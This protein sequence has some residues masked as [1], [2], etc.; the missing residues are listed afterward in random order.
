MNVFQLIVYTITAG[1]FFVNI[2]KRMQ[3]RELRL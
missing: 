2:Y 1:Y 3:Q